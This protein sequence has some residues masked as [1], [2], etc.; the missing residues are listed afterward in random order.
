[1]QQLHYIH[2]KDMGFNKEQ[3]LMVDFAFNQANQYGAFKSELTKVSGIEAV[4]QLGGSIPG[5]EE[6]IENSFVET[7]KPAEQQQWFSLMF[8]GHDFEKVLNIEFLEGHSFVVGSST[9][10][11]GFIVNESAAKALGWGTDVVGRR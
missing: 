5:Q 7:G 4:S 2:N 9:D 6:V 1:Y 11:V 10:S 3:I 8:T